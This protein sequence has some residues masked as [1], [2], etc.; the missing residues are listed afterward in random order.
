MKKKNIELK[1]KIAM[2]LLIALTLVKSIRESI[3]PFMTMYDY[4]EIAEATSFCYEGL[5][6]CK[7]IYSLILMKQRTPN[8]HASAIA[9][10]TTLK[11]DHIFN[12]WV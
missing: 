11:Y 4:Q 5:V 8:K 2:L 3:I 10:N 9:I 1:F 7:S 6:I 12:F